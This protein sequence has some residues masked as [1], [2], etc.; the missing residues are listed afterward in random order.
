MIITSYHQ[1]NYTMHFLNGVHHL[2][3]CSSLLFT[4]QYRKSREQK[5]GKKKKKESFLF[6]DFFN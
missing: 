5:K 1:H 4:P 6:V 3:F 2:L